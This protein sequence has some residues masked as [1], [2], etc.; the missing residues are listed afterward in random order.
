[1]R[2]GLRRGLTAAAVGC[3]LLTGCSSTVVGSASPG[4]GEPTDVSA[5]DFPITAAGD[6]QEDTSARNALVDLNTF[7]S[8]A[9]PDAFGEPFQPLQ[10]GYFSVDSDNID[11]SAYPPTGIGCARSPDDPSD[12]ALNAHFDPNCDVI[13]YD[14]VLLKK[15]SDDYGRSLP[16]VVMAHEFGHAIQDR[17]G[18]EGP[19]INQET[20]ADC[21]AGAWTRW[22]VDGHAQHVSIRVPELDQVLQGYG[23]LADAP[24]D[25]PGNSQ[26]HGSFFDRIAG[27]S[28]GYEDGV[29]A[30]RDRFGS[31]RVYTEIAFTDRD[32]GTQGNVDYPTAVQA[33]EATLPPFWDQVFPAAFGKDFQEPTIKPFDGTAPDCGDMAGTERDLGFCASDSTVYYDEQDLVQPAYKEFGDFVVPTAISLP[34]GLAVRSELGKSTDDSAATRSAV[35]LTGWYE[36]QVFN[37]AFADGDNGYSISAGD[38]DEAVHFLLEYGV[39]DS[40]FPNTDQS[41]FELFQDYR[42]G[43]QQGGSPCDVGA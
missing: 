38:I 12:V 1:M 20:Q 43:F 2:H 25:S 5:N 36:A 16:A 8:Q 10:G 34:Y 21:F 14:T 23:L 28:E 18:F 27:F 40:V 13:A 33:T 39:K 41:G 3:V 7:W 26:A 35:C 31:D 32:Q 6:D 42:A 4:P 37:G 19:S 29:T 11:D 22:A 17:F 15:L 24:G 30:C 9:Y